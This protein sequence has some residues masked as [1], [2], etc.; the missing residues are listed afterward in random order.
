MSVPVIP[1]TEPLLVAFFRAQPELAELGERIYTALPA[2][3]TW[4]A[5][6]VV[7][8]GGWPA[9][10]NPLWLDEAWHQV[11]IWGTTKNEV[12]ALARLMRALA[13]YRLPGAHP[14][15]VVSARRLG[16]LHDAPD[17]TYEPAKP[18][19]R[20]DL[21]VLLHPAGAPAG[22]TIRSPL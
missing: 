4:P 14:G 1:D 8:W 17:T 21:S 3:P 12:S 2:R 10:A 22:P 6:R 19:F 18:H 20:F 16:M 13:A 15:A 7:R 11:D 5:A 9:L